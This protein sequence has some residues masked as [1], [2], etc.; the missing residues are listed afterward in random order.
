MSFHQLLSCPLGIL[1]QKKRGSLSCQNDKC[2][3]FS[4]LLDVHLL[5]EERENEI[6]DKHG[7]S[8]V[9]TTIYDASKIMQT[10]EAQNYDTD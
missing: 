1:K 4:F 8:K 10:N 5:K 7:S 3:N 2:L 9:T 6:G